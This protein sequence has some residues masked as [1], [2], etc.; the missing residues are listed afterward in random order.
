MKGR[1]RILI[2]STKTKKGFNHPGA[3]AGKSPAKKDLGDHTTP[4]IIRLNQKGSPNLSVS[5]RCLVVLNTY[6]TKPIKFK[7]TNTRN[8]LDKNTWLI[9]NHRKVVR[10]I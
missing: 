5:T 8:N 6:G 3:P 2:I 7:R 4:D 9:G 10:L 1:T